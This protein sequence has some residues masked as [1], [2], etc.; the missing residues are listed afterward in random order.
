MINSASITFMDNSTKSFNSGFVRNFNDLVTWLR[1]NDDTP[2]ELIL[3]G[4]VIEI[5]YKPAIKATKLFNR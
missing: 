5:L 1:T 4:D 2:C 3:E